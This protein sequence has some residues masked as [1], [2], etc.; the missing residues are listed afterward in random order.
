L[1]GI[2]TPPDLRILYVE[3]EPS[4]STLQWGTAVTLA[5]PGPIDPGKLFPEDPNPVWPLD[6]SRTWQPTF[7]YYNIYIQLPLPDNS[8]GDPTSAVFYGTTALHDGTKLKIT[9]DAFELPLGRKVRF[10][11]Q[12]VTDRGGI[13]EINKCCY[14]DVLF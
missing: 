10:H 7:L 9:P 14:V 6:R 13:L 12:G 5:P 8:F 1:Q 2:V 3:Y 11:V 4:T